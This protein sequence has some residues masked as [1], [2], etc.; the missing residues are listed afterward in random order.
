MKKIIT[1]I[2]LLL[3]GVSSGAG[4]YLPNQDAYATARGNAFVATADR[5]SAVHYNPG[6]LVQMDE[7][8]LQA[9]VYGI[10]LRNTASTAVGNSS[11][12]NKWQ[13]APHV[14]YAHPIR[15]GLVLGFGLNSPFGLGT[16][17][18]N[19][20]NTGFRT[21][22]NESI[23]RML[24][25]TTAIAYRINDEL[26]V[27]VGVSANYLD[28]ELQQ[29]LGFVAGDF[30]RFEGD[31]VSVSGS[32]GM[33]W[34][35]HEKHSFGATVALE[36]RT[37]LEGD[38]KSNLD[39]TVV[40]TG[41]ADLNFLTP[42]RAAVGY[43]Y[44]PNSRWNIEANIEWLDWESLNT[45]TLNSPTGPT[46]IPFEWESSFIYVIGASYSIG[47]GYIVSAGYDYNES[48]QPDMF[49][50]PGVAD[51][52]RHWFNVGV[53]RELED[54]NWHFAYQFGYSN[55]DVTG[56]VIGTNGTYESRHHGVMLTTE[57]RF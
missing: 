4:F 48:S 29:G 32:V 53:G 52:N 14:Y 31:G 23:L 10:Q 6:G 47:S 46:P 38:T 25:F 40:P 17:W 15:D 39:P 35:P 44:R 36:T 42:M 13:L 3:P 9:G 45:L 18:G 33:L 49:F 26:S 1:L 28:A 24:A 5:A 22:A 8:S 19:G 20:D 2:A 11:A 12:E 54:W 41:A 30:L 27:G 51:A 21:V 34:Q 50:N 37:K 56:S 57:F 55:R 43:S 16:D 7:R